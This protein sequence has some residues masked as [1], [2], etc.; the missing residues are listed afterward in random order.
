RTTQ[1]P[2]T[3]CLLASWLRAGVRRH[4]SDAGASQPDGGSAG[5]RLRQPQ[6]GSRFPGAGG[7]GK[8]P[9]T[10]GFLGLEDLPSHDV[11]DDLQ[12]EDVGEEEDGFEESFG[13]PSSGTNTQRAGP[14]ARKMWS[15]ARRGVRSEEV[16]ARFS[17]RV[18]MTGTMVGPG[19][20]ALMF[21]AFARVKYR[22]TKAL[23]TISPFILR[24]IDAF[25]TTELVLLLNGH[26]KLEYERLDNIHLLLNA[27]CHRSDE[28][29]GRHVALA[30]NAVASFYIYQPSFWRKV[31]MCLPKIV[32][33]MNPLELSNLVSA[34]AR[35]D[36]RDPRSMIIIARMCRRCALRHLFSQETLATTMNAFSKLDFNHPKLAKVFE[37][38]AIVKLDRALEL[39][40]AYRKSGS[41]RGADVFDVQALVLVLQTLVCLVGTSDEVALKLLTLLA[42]SKDE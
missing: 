2:S 8:A 9:L 22:D 13:S 18:V 33:S 19:D 35:V 38:A 21:L 11:M 7:R 37:D 28:W 24:H 30:S 31:A 25:S 27:I 29:T 23:D 26:K 36:R 41:L 39:G 14:L 1:T 10:P 15:C 32:W 20:V 16:W 40:S 5:L 17:Q 34:M 12:P 3:S 4:G 42:W 6:A